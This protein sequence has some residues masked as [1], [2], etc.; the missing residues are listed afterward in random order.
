MKTRYLSNAI[1]KAKQKLVRQAKENGLWEN[2]GQT[3]VNKLKD[4]Y[5]DI[6]KYTDDMNAARAK[7]A[8]FNEWCMNFNVEEV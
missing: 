2:F 4:K 3:E 8:K 5:I 1:T 6:S 7:I